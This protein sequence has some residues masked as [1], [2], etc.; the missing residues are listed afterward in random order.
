MLEVAQ[1]YRAAGLSFF[2]S[3]LSLDP[4]ARWERQLYNEIDKCDLSF[5]LWWKAA[6]TSEWVQKEARYA[7]ALRGKSPSQTPDIVPL[8]L[9]G[10][11]APRPP[12]F[13]QHLHFTIGCGWRSH[14]QNQRHSHCST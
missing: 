4:G 11:P 9:D 3:I 10:P 6:S 14:Q 8:I 2:Q 7:L 13:L 12:N 5:L 1:S